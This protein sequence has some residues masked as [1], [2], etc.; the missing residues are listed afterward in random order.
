MSLVLNL[1]SMISRKC[2]KVI[3]MGSFNCTI[4]I[5]EEIEATDEEE[6]KRL[7]IKKLDE[8]APILDV[9]VE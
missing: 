2:K 7:F 8:Y 1:A 6:T 5:S 4:R 9:D 3:E